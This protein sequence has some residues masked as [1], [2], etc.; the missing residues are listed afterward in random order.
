MASASRPPRR[1]RATFLMMTRSPSVP[2]AISVPGRS[3]ACGRIAAGIVTCPLELISVAVPPRRTASAARPPRAQAA[4]RR[5]TRSAP[6]A[7]QA[8]RPHHPNAARSFGRDRAWF[9]PGAWAAARARSSRTT[10]QTVVVTGRV[11]NGR[12]PALPARSA[13]R[14]EG[15]EK[16]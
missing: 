8:C 7:G 3:P 12:R 9:P 5:P 10:W 16:A 2:N 11:K 15:A 6:V 1:S 13:T 4:P 14:T